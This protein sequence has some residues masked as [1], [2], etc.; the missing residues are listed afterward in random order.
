MFH[1]DISFTT[2]EKA[3]QFG[4]DAKNFMISYKDALDFIK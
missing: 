3:V 4:E 1:S 2:K